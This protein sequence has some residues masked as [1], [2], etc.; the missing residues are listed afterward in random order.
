M[1]FEW[2]HIDKNTARAWV[3]GGWIV[4]YDNDVMSNVP[5]QGMM[6]GYEWRSSMVFV[7]D[8]EHKWYVV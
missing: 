1:Q 2:H 8:P 6:D 5:D 4:R 3:A 7:P